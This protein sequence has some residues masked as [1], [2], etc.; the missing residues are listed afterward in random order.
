MWTEPKCEQSKD[1]VLKQM[2]SVTKFDKIT[3]V[4]GQFFV[5]AALGGNTKMLIKLKATY[6]SC[7]VDQVNP[8][9]TNTQDLKMRKH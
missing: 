1:C 5:A 7:R 6:P 4:F 2:I 9:K 8:C 3:L